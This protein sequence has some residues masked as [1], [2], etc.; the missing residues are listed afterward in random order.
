M[1]TE[2]KSLQYFDGTAIHWYES[3]YDYFPKELQ[4]ANKKAP[5]KL[6]IETEGCIDAD[7]PYGKKTTGIE[8]RQQIGGM[9]GEKKKNIYI[10]STLP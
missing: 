6:F 5:S 4:Y 7:V 8:R 2:M 10:Q 1:C 3:T 9:I